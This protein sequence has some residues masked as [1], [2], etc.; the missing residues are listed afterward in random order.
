MKA[1]AHLYISGKV[2]GVYYRGFTQE[3]AYSLGLNGWSKNLPDGRVEAVFEGEKDVIEAVIKKCY[4]GP[5]AARVTDIQ[6]I[7]D[8]SVENFTDFSIRYF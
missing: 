4:Q 2:Q 1:R 7:W 5:P 6:V 3:I 8:E